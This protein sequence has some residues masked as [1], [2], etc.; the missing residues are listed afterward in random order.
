M[1]KILLILLFAPFA[2]V[3]AQVD[4]ITKI[5][6][7]PTEVTAILREYFDECSVTRRFIDNKGIVEVVFYKDSLSR[8]NYRLTAIID[9]RYLDNP[10]SKYYTHP[11]MDM[12]FLF[13]DADMSGKIIYP[14][15]SLRAVEELKRCVGD[16]VYIRPPKTDRWVEYMDFD[17]KMKR[18]KVFVISAGNPW[19]T[20]LYTFFSEGGYKKL[21]S[22]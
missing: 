13:Y 15:L 5:K 21:K 22:V 8:D 18:R 2:T 14:Q 17:G 10:P 19:N 1:K 3:F 7:M 16:R 6:I 20:T 12:L 4:S 9:D 11:F